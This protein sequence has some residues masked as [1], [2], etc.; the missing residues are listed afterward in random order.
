MDFGA[1]TARTRIAHLPEIIMFVTIDDMSFRQELFPIAGSLV[2]TR[3]AFG[4]TS[5]EHGCIQTVGV[6]FQHFYQVFPCPTDRF[7]FEIVTKRPVSQHLK[8]GVVVRVVSYL[9]QVVMFA[10]HT[11]TLL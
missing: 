7:L 6:Q 3:K 8:H 4:R 2:V 5:F 1:R 9:F 11:K 10:T